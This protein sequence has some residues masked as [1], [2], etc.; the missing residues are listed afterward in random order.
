VTVCRILSNSTPVR[1]YVRSRLRRS[2]RYIA[3]GKNINVIKATREITRSTLPDIVRDI[4]DR[5]RTSGVAVSDMRRAGTLETDM[6]VPQMLEGSSLDPATHDITRLEG[7]IVAREIERRN[8]SKFTWFLDGSQK[9]LPV[10][11]IGVVPVIV[12]IAVVGILERDEEGVCSLRGETLVERLTWFVPM[13]T[14]SPELNHVID[15][16]ID[17]GQ[18]IRDPLEQF[19][20]NAD[21]LG[22]YHAL[23]GNYG[24]L[25]Y[26]SQQLAGKVRGTIEQDSVQYWDSEIRDP[27]QDKW[28]VVDGRLQGQFPNA[29]GFVKDPS[30][31]HLFGE[32]A[33]ELFSLPQGHRTTAYQLKPSAASDEADDSELRNQVLTM[34]YQRM[35]AAT[36]L[37][38]RHAL[39]RLEASNEVWEP[40]LIDDIASWL[41]AERIPRP[42]KDSR[43]P[44]LL[45][46]IHQLELMLKRRIRA[47]TVG[48]P[49]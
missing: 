22:Q 10:W 36:G 11:R 34:W 35:W 44:T 38:A 48:W 17:A 47:M 8:E 15:I 7:P 9:T 39:V 4:E 20:R 21:G 6:N 1:V 5:M 16:L 49:S 19:A 23:A 13:R 42:T 12:G 46:P 3:P 18:D 28:L 45:Y 26:F 40:E 32:E 41:M 2:V 27:R 25:L 24:H 31:Q 33:A 43:W 14:K 30:S 37:D 29:I